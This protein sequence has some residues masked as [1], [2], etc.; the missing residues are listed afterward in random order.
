MNNMHILY[1]PPYQ[2]R[3]FKVEQLEFWHYKPIH[4]HKIL[5]YTVYI[6]EA[7]YNNGENW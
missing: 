2:V 4:K 1:A 6:Y 7:T 3:A 5:Q